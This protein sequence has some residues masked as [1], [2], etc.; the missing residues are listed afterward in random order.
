LLFQRL[1]LLDVESLDFMAA[2]VS[3]GIGLAHYLKFL[4]CIS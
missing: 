4:S 2:V 1:D 3:A